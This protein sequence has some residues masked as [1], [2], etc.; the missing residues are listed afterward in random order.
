MTS[1]YVQ[2][3]LFNVPAIALQEE[4]EYKV[5]WKAFEEVYESAGAPYYTKKFAGYSD[6]T[7]VKTTAGL[8]TKTEAQSFAE[9]VST[10]LYEY[11]GWYE[12]VKI[13]N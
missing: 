4:P 6:E 11:A 3:D 7:R 8:M 10:G 9:F 13:N 1:K 2:A 5:R 12:I